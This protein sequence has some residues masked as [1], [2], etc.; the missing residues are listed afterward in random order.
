MLKDSK[1]IMAVFKG[2]LAHQETG[3]RFRERRIELV[4][5]VQSAIRSTMKRQR[6]HF[7]DL[8]C[9]YEKWTT[10]VL[11]IKHC[12]QLQEQQKSTASCSQI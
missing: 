12:T 1:N 9:D 7:K 2:P 4:T 5:V 8:S 3:Q 6:K 10:I 11:V